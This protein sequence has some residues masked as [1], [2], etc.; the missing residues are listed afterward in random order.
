MLNLKNEYYLQHVVHRLVVWHLFD[1][2]FDIQIV[3]LTK[4]QCKNR[5]KSSDC[6]LKKMFFRQIETK[7]LKSSL[8]NLHFLSWG[9][10]EEVTLS[11]LSVFAKDDLLH[12]LITDLNTRWSVAEQIFKNC[13]LVNNWVEIQLRFLFYLAISIEI[14]NT[15][16]FIGWPIESQQ[17]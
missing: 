2:W 3:D 12:L 5:C 10:N 13:F 11:S 4:S 16:W 15:D 6:L 1:S 17:F 9:A 14:V 7:R 8:F